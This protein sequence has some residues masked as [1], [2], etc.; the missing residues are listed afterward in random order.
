[1][2]LNINF[3]FNIMIYVFDLDDTLLQ[4]D[5]KT[6][7]NS[8]YLE[9]YPANVLPTIQLFKTIDCMKFIMTNRHPICAHEIANIFNIPITQVLCRNYALSLKDVYQTVT[10]FKNQNK[11]IM[12]KFLSDMVIDKINKLNKLRKGFN[13]SIVFFD[14]MYELFKEQIKKSGLK[15]ERG[16]MIKEPL[17]NFTLILK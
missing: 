12:E 9:L 17:K 11:S 16:I 8:F 15:L 7:E 6:L 5:K 13:D 2:F 1:M 10:G 3:K 4:V 14:D